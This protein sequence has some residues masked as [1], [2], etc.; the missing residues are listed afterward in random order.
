MSWVLVFILGVILV[1]LVAEKISVLEKLG[2]AMPVGLG[3][4][5]FVL[6]LKHATSTS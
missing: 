5:T 6:I 2:F 3:V 4:N 1:N